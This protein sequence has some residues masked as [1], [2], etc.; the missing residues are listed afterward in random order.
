[1]SGPLTLSRDACE[2]D[3]T[4]PTRASS[5]TAEL[6]SA[7]GARRLIQAL[8]DAASPLRV[9]LREGGVQQLTC[10]GDNFSAPAAAAAAALVGV[11]GAEN[12]GEAMAMEA[13][14]L[15]VVRLRGLRLRSLPDLRLCPQLEDVG[16]HDNLIPSVPAAVAWLPRWPD[17]PDALTPRIAIDL[18]SNCLR[19][20]S[21]WPASFPRVQVVSLDLSANCLTVAP[22]GEYSGSVDISRNNIEPRRA[23]LFALNPVTGD[24]VDPVTGDWVDPVT[25]EVLTG[26]AGPLTGVAGPLTGV[27][28]PLTR[29]WPLTAQLPP[30]PSGLAKPTVYASTQTVHASSVNQGVR[31]SLAVVLSAAQA[32]RASCSVKDALKGLTDFVRDTV[33][34]DHLQRLARFLKGTSVMSCEALRELAV[35]CADP[36]DGAAPTQFFY[37]SG[38]SITYPALLSTAWALASDLDARNGGTDVRRRLWQEIKEG[39]E[40]CFTGRVS[41]VVNAF[42]GFVEGVAIGI[43]QREQLQARAQAI[44]ARQHLALASDEAAAAAAS[45]AASGAASP[46]AIDQPPDVREAVVDAMQPPH[47]PAVRALRH[48]LVRALHQAMD[49]GGPGGSADSL[50]AVERDA[51]LEA[52]DGMLPSRSDAETT[53]AT[54]TE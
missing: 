30:G 53:E 20:V 25:G 2:L 48:E 9:L 43:S 19:A 26:V 6:L 10:S 14:A 23:V 28:G 3:A 34:G 33:D 11:P 54:A 15:R 29:L 51:W 21:D 31:A 35:H 38:G 1:M 52:F 18:S 27:A 40:M 45:A 24:W 41:R 7:L 8:S 13:P 32:A 37:G 42:S 5:V 12:L 36:A 50:T 44:V 46:E 22:P 47:G 39:T 4:L 16:L 49:G 17:A